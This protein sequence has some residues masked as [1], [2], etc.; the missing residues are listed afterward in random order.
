MSTATQP[1]TSRMALRIA[2]VAESLGI[3]R[4][5]IERERAAGRFPK[6]DKMIGKSP[7]WKPETIHAWLSIESGRN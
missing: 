6:P 1:E 3:T 4:R 2:E 5:S 7:L